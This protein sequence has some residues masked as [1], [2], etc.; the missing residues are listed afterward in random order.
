MDAHGRARAAV[1][2]ALCAGTAAAVR[3]RIADLAT[4]GIDESANLWLGTLIRDGNAPGVG[5]ASSVGT[6][7]LAGAPLLAAPLSLLPD[8]LA[9][10]R[11]LTLAQLVALVALGLAVARGR[12]GRVCV[13]ALLAFAPASL[14]AAASLWN[15]YLALPITAAITALL[16][17]L[18]E[19]SPLGRGGGFAAAALLV[20]LLLLQ[21]GVHLA[22]FADLAVQGALA[23]ALLGLAGPRAR[24]AGLELAVAI[25]FCALLVLYRPWLTRTFGLPPRAALLVYCALA[26]AAVLGVGRAVGRLTGLAR[27]VAEAR[28]LAWTVPA[29]LVICAGSAALTFWGAQVGMM[30]LHGDGWGAALLAAHFAVA[31]LA[32]PA[33]PGMIADCR[34][35]AAPRDLLRAWCPGRERGAALL[36][37]NAALLLVAR[38]ALVPSAFRPDGRPDL[39]LPLL[40]ALLAPA[41]LLVVA[42]PRAA[43]RAWATGV[44]G[45]LVAVVVAFAALGPSPR[46]WQRYPL[47]LPPSEMRALVDW[48]AAQPDA[49]GADGRLDVGYDLEQ[50]RERVLRVACAPSIAPWYTV[51]RPFDWL[52]LRRHGLRDGRE[53]TCA[54]GGG[55]RWVVTYRTAAAPV[56]RQRRLELPHLV[57]WE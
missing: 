8:L 1:A 2:L 28:W 20:T 31:A 13:V 24:P 18:A 44:C 27:P 52:F 39:L 12:R 17:V 10:S 37:A 34:A 9:V 7:N 51:S 45:A 40:P 22:G 47:F 32:L 48:I 15:Q 19:R 35:G 50:G 56:G 4:W 6:K 26:I 57:V 25:G 3:W 30:A 43:L 14:L 33:V 38:A 21:P 36:L 29:V 55:G 41:L 11:A 16:L 23:M 5:L 46:F 53:G 49:V 54:R 42:T